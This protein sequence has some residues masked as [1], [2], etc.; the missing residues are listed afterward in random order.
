MAVQSL[1]YKF[2]QWHALAKLRIHSESTLLFLDETFKNLS[3]MLRKF[4]DHTCAAFNTVELPREKAAR[5]R[6]FAQR[7][8]IHNPSPESSG[9]RTKKFNLSTYKFHAMGDYVSTIRFF[10]TTDSFTTQMVRVS[11]IP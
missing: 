4:R 10:G 8:E 6:R 1:L 7:S 9:A 3:R 5:L 2:A 11:Y